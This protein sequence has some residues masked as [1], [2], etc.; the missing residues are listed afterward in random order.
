MAAARH[1]RRSTRA[2][3]MLGT[4]RRIE[5]LQSSTRNG[6]E[7]NHRQ[8]VVRIFDER[9]RG[10]HNR[11]TCLT[12]SLDVLSLF[13]V[14]PKVDPQDFGHNWL[15]KV[16]WEVR[17]VLR[18][19]NFIPI[20]INRSNPAIQESFVLGSRFK[21]LDLVRCNVGQ[22]NGNVENRVSIERRAHKLLKVL[23][24]HIIS[25]R[26]ERWNRA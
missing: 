10:S 4:S 23:E 15:S 22:E 7:G 5:V 14:R 17:V 19:S 25:C 18:E 16:D 11:L 3:A 6:D 21:V 24:T 8:H 13:R 1:A 12:R 26:K 20:S 2:I 9:Q